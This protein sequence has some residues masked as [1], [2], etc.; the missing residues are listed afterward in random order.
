MRW[1]H[2]V[3]FP[4]GAKKWNKVKREKAAKGRGKE[5]AGSGRK[6]WKASKDEIGRLKEPPPLHIRVND[7]N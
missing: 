1:M 4:P 7:R 3:L 6:Q 2:I 5:G